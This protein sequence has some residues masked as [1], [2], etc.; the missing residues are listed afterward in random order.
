MPSSKV[1]YKPTAYCTATQGEIFAVLS[2]GSCTRSYVVFIEPLY[3]SFLLFLSLLCNSL[4]ALIAVNTPLILFLDCVSL[5][6]AA[7]VC[8]LW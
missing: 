8:K 2:N 7:C 3:A 6:E 1:R 4:G 5:S